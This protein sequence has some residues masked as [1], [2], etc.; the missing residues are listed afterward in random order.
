M[1]GCSGSKRGWLL[2]V[3]LAVTVKGEAGLCAAERGKW[4]PV[5]VKVGT[6]VE[7]GDERLWF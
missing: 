2:A 7:E 3:V 6:V 5:V 1:V 4:M